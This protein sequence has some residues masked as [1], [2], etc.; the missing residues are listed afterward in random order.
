MG[1]RKRKRAS[2]TLTWKA[3]KGFF[4]LLFKGILKASPFVLLGGIGFGIFWGIRENLYADPGFLVQSLEVVPEKALSP[5]RVQELEKRFLN[6]NLFKISPRGLAQEIQTDPT[7]RQA[8]VIRKFP[9]TLRVEISHRDPFVQIQFS[10]HGPYYSA[11]EDEI[12]LGKEFERDKNLLLIEAF[13]TK[14][15]KFENG[16]GLSVAGFREAIELVK[17]FQ[18]HPLARSE[19]IDRIRL[20]HLGNV[21][22]VLKEGPELRFGRQ[23]I[24]KLYTLGSLTPLLKGPDRKQI[25]YIELQ[26]QDL[27][28]KKK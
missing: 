24:K 2:S 18:T 6:R 19:G 13:E 1:K 4:R 9:R 25:I 10:P 28:V 23:P 11:A 20:D 3:T 8:R 16:E 5:Q 17:A 7:I 26:Y 21:S 12:V 15:S 14:V 22:L 27:I